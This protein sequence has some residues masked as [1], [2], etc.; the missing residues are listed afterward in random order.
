MM[1]LFIPMF[2]LYMIGVAVC[3]IFPP[4]YEIDDAAELAEQVAV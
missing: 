3:R 2:G 4:Q 1:Y